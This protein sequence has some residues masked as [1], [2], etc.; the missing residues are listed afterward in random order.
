MTEKLIPLQSAYIRQSRDV[1]NNAWNIFTEDN[2]KIGRLSNELNPKQA[3]SYLHFAR[4]FELKALNIGI[5]FGEAQEHDK[6]EIVFQKLK[7]KI[8]FLEKQN[9]GLSENL[10]RLIIGEEE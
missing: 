7:A 2:L 4:E 1:D 9:I 6:A 3:M 10:E 8:D 5:R